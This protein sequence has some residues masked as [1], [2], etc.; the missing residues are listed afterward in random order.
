MMINWN[1]LLLIWLILVV[2]G[3]SVYAYPT[4]VY[5]G[6]E[7]E[8]VYNILDSVPQEYLSTIHSIEFNPEHYKFWGIYWYSPKRI[9]LYGDLYNES[10]YIQRCVLLHEIGHHYGGKIRDRTE[11]FANA[12]ANKEGCD[13]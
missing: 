4:I 6:I 13:I 3:S 8:K 7:K 11:D 9:V 12:F 2:F 10:L 5:S 1:K